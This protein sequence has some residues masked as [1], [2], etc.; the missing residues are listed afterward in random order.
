MK[1]H[2]LTSTSILVTWGE[3][4]PDK[5]HGHIRQYTVIYKKI[6][7]GTDR[8]VTVM[9]RRVELKDLEKFSVCDIRVLA[10]T[11]KGDGP[12]SDPIF[13]YTDEDSK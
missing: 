12:P 10:A 5:Q 4:P 9:A 7:G 2:S 11:I 3:V 8:T 6:P 1:G 13:V